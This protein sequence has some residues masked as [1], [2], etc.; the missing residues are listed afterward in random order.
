MKRILFLILFV[1]TFSSAE[2]NEYLSDVYFANGID[3]DDKEAYEA[4][5]DINISTMIEYPESYKYVAKWNI[6]YNHTHGIGIDLYESMLQKIDEDWRI[7]YALDISGLLK[8]TYGG[9]AK[10]VAKKVLRS[11]SESGN[12]DSK[13]K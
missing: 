1:L 8:F 2:I 12:A 11:H 4:L 10:M 3:T 5:G 7:K 13:I 6:S 9:I